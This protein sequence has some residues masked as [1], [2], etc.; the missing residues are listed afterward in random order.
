MQKASNFR[1]RQ[2]A[3]EMVALKGVAA[4]FPQKG[5]LVGGFHSFRH[6]LHLEAVGQG[7][8][9]DHHRPVIV[10]GGDVVDESPIDLE[11]VDG[12]ALQIAQRRIAGA[13]VIQG[14]V[15]KCNAVDGGM[16]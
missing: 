16:A 2:G 15:L 11:A 6:Y 5:R 4:F 8:D 7:D 1:R 13:E 10:V 14:Q 12:E 9:G 3:A